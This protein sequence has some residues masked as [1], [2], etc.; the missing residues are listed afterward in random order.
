MEKWHKLWTVRQPIKRRKEKARDEDQEQKLREKAI[1]EIRT[2][3]FT[4]SKVIQVADM[5]VRM[6]DQMGMLFALSEL[7]R[8]EH[9]V[10]MLH[11]NKN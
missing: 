7:L 8:R 10:D 5:F 6:S 2:L 4:G 11:G 3:E 1:N 9:I